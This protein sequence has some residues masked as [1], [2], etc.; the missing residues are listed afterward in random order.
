[1]EGYGMQHTQRKSGEEDLGATDRSIEIDNSDR[2]LLDAGD[3]TTGSRRL[4]VLNITAEES[5]SDSS[6]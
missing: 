6:E 5:S 2:K 1:M 4:V 3:N